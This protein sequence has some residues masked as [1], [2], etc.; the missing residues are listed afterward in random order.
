MI[1]H[2]RMHLNAT[3]DQIWA[4][5]ADPPLMEQWDPKCVRCQA[6]GNPVRA[7]LRYRATF[8]LSGPEQETQ[9]EVLE[10]RPGRT[11]AIRFTTQAPRGGQVDETFRLQSSGEGTEVTHEID[12][13]HSGLPWWLKVFMKVLDLFGHQRGK[14]SLDGIAEL[15][16]RSTQ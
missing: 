6:D 12:F 10:C 8:R 1:L 2:E 7:G 9:C 5:L 11:L 14:S 3:P 4:I 13:K 15:A 16:G